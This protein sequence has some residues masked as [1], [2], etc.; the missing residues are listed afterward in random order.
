MVS[1]EVFVSV[2]FSVNVCPKLK[3]VSFTSGG[4]TVRCDNTG[5]SRTGT[6]SSMELARRGTTHIMPN[7]ATTA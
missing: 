5:F 2:R 4:D 1:F 3:S 6:W 7:D